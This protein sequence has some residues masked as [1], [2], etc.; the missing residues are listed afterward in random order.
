MHKN[1]A[2]PLHFCMWLFISTWQLQAV[3]TQIV[4]ASGLDLTAYNNRVL[5][6][7]E[8]MSTVNNECVCA[9]AYYAFDNNCVVCP[10][11]TYK[12]EAGNASCTPCPVN[13]MSFSG[14]DDINNCLCTQ[15]FTSV[16]STCIA[17]ADNTFKSYIGNYSCLECPSFSVSNAGST[18]SNE[19]TDCKCDQGYTGNDGTE[20]SACVEHTYKDSIGDATCTQCP[21]N[22][23]TLNTTSKDVAECL[24]AEGY[25]KVADTCNQCGVGTYKDVIGNQACT[26]CPSNSTSPVGSTSVAACLCEAGFEKDGPTGG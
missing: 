12:S 4:L 22:T 11:H 10:D 21:A 6:C 8:H 2:T 25:T 26:L 15:G 19:V 18:G 14:S 13:S 5:Y 3:M 9:P 24:C 1:F 16:D 17:C 20:C 7:G 23:K